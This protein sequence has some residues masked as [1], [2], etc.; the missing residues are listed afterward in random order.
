MGD[1]GN[2]VLDYGKKQ[3]I[4]L[5]THWQGAR[6]FQILRAALARGRSRWKDAPYLARIIFSELIRDEVLELTG[7]GLTPYL[8][9]NE[10]DV[11]VVDLVREQV[12]LCEEENLQAVKRTWGF[13]EFVRAED[14]RM[15]GA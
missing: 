2:I 4:Y 9:D 7:Y 3:R 12:L 13:E 15:E 8:T 11:L 1:R 5:Y 6:L 10:H 14:A